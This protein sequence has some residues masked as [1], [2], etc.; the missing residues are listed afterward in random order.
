LLA[1]LQTQVD[2]YFD[3]VMVMADDVEV[4]QNRLATLYNMRLLFLD[5]ADFSVLQ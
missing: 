3:E 4:R 2:E 5:V 1:G